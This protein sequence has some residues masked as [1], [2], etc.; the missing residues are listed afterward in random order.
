MYVYIYMYVCMYM[1]VYI[2]IYIIYIYIYIYIM[3]SIYTQCHP[4]TYFPIIELVWVPKYW[5]QIFRGQGLSKDIRPVWKVYCKP[6]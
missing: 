2:Y 5:A 3:M 1:Y 4:E 6:I